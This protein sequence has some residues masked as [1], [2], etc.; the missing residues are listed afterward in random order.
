MIRKTVLACALLLS[1]AAIIHADA[2][3]LRVGD[4]ASGEVTYHRVDTMRELWVGLPGGDVGSKKLLKELREACDETT[5]VAVI[6]TKVRDRV[7]ASEGELSVLRT[8]AARSALGQLKE[9]LKL[10]GKWTRI[11]VVG[12]FESCVDAVALADNADAGIDGVLLIDPPVE[13]L[14]AK[15]KHD[16]RVGVDVLLHPRSGREFEREEA[17]ILERL[18]D[19]GSS[20]RV[21]FKIPQN[22][23][24]IAC[25]KS[26][27]VM[28]TTG[29]TS[30]M[31]ALL[32]RISTRPQRCLACSTRS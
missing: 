3:E 6:D 20:A 15:D 25:S 30:M 27:R 13:D 9:E 19:W 2:E 29:P 8:V 14:P 10:N 22:I 7:P 1:C 12:M 32:T 4:L 26:C 31:P 11:V 24:S 28:V 23:T 21:V 16:A 5:A 18:G 17:R